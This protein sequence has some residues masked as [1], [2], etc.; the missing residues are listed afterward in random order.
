MFVA[1]VLPHI[2]LMIQ[3]NVRKQNQK[4]EA[5]TKGTKEATEANTTQTS[6]PPQKRTGR[7]YVM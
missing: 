2:E 6:K 5:Q 7:A 3:D 4:Q 1:Q